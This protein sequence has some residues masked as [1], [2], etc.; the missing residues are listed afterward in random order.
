[1]SIAVELE[2]LPERI[3]EY[4]SLAFLVTVGEDHRAHVVS[5]RVGEAGDGRLTLPAGRR[6]RANV[7][8]RPSVTIVW[9][10]GPDGRYSLIIDG[11]AQAPGDGDDPVSIRP[12]SAVLHLLARP[13][14]D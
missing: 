11:A 7:E 14:A 6:T 10:P 5:V 13:T 4:G 12:S 1:M 8:A 2:A 3:A 9:P